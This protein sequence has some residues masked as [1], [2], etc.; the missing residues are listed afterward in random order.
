MFTLKFNHG[1]GRPGGRGLAAV[2]S[3]LTLQ[4][5]AHNFDRMILVR[6]RRSQEKPLP[7]GPESLR[8]SRLTQIS[9]S[10]SGQKSRSE[11]S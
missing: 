4:I 5:L 9:L 7:L 3:E 1:V 11:P 2:R 8:S 6:A 10:S